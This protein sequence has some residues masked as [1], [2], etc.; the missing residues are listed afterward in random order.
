MTKSSEHIIKEIEDRIKEYE[1]LAVEHDNNQDAVHELNSATN[2]L[3]N[4]LEWIKG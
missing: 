3:N 2:E 1:I 4:L